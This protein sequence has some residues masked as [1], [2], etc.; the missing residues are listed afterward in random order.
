MP[1][2]QGSLVDEQGNTPPWIELHNPTN[3]AIGLSGWSLTNDLTNPSLYVLP[4]GLTLPA[5]GFLVLYADASPLFGAN[6][7]G[8]AIPASGGV[9]GL[10]DP[11]GAGSSLAYMTPKTNEA[12][13]RVPD[14]CVG[15]ACLTIDLL[16]TPGKTNVV[17]PTQVVEVLAPGGTYKYYD[18][19]VAPPATWI[20]A[21]FNDGAW[22]SGPAPLGYG[23][24]FIVTTV[25]YGPNAANKYVTTWF[26][27]TF[28]VTGTAKVLAAAVELMRDDGARAF[29]NGV[30]VA[31]TNL[32][33]G[34][35]DANT[36]ASGSAGGAGETT[37][38][39][40]PV[41]PSVLVEGK[42]VL[43]IEV[44]QASVGSSDMGMDARVTVEVPLP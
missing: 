40:F 9:V 17:V 38:F 8:F 44:H 1:I 2:N 21:G 11:K 28:T 33:P 10:F 19:G 24:A 30:E 16:G 37:F 15:D 42:N 4:G 35:I 12:I 14:C 31:R 36:L 27:T 20:D 6:H 13:A 34:P 3:A 43:A 22:A 41:D 25:S 18:M 32:D 5:G 23:D 29:I 7:L 26:R 39:P